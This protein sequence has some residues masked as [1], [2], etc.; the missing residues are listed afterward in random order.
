MKKLRI[1]FMTLLLTSMALTFHHHSDLHI[2]SHHE[3]K[4]ILLL[5]DWNGQSQWDDEEKQVFPLH[6]DVE[7]AYM[8][9]ITVILLITFTRNLSNK[10]IFLN[11]IFHQSNYVILT[12]IL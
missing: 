5:D 10:F 6:A 3:S 9:S 2:H 7:L 1:L 11:P 8:L 4:A 12:P